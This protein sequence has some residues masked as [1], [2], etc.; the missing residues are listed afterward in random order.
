MG[1][2]GGGGATTAVDFESIFDAWFCVALKLHDLSVG[3][4]TLEVGCVR[5][6]VIYRTRIILL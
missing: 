3:S 2:I 6:L 5:G 4:N 1:S